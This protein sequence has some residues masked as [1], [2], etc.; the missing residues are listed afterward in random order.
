MHVG[1]SRH[2][3]RRYVLQLRHEGLGHAHLQEPLHQGSAGVALQLQAVSR[4]M[5]STGDK[6]PCTTCGQHTVPRSPSG[7][8]ISTLTGSTYCDPTKK[9]THTR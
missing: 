8:L 1:N 9:T 5:G 3:L 7:T 2:V 6:K 4:L